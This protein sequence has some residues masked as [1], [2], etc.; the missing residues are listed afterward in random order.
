MPDIS[1]QAMHTVSG[2]IRLQVRV[3]VDEMGNVTDARMKS[4]KP[5][6][7]FARQALEAARQWKFSPVVEDG[8][9]LAS[10]WMVQFILTHRAI[11][12]SVERL[13]P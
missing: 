12:D 2:K 6:K 4:T 1:S 11:D 9:P 5:S 13:K 3:K 10:E 7:Y 8:K